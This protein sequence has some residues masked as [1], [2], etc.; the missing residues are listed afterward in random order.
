MASL[1]RQLSLAGRR[2]RGAPAA[3]S[4]RVDCQWMEFE[5]RSRPVPRGT[6]YNLVTIQKEGSKLGVDNGR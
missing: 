2:V 6:R 5:F 3:A 4:D 1:A